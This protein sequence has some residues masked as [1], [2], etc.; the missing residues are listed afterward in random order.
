MLYWNVVV[1]QWLMP[2]VQHS[3][4]QSDD[5]VPTDLLCESHGMVVID[6]SQPLLVPVSHFQ[7]SHVCSIHCIRVVA[8]TNELMAFHRVDRG[9]P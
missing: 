7:V 8:L 6:A 4:Q 2:E 9:C 3:V 5:G 1:V